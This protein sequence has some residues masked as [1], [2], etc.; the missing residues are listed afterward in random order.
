MKATFLQLISLDPHLTPLLQ[1]IRNFSPQFTT[2]ARCR[3]N[4]VKAFKSGGR[5]IMLTTCGRD[6][7]RYVWS[8][9][10]L[11][12]TLSPP[13]MPRHYVQLTARAIASDCIMLSHA[14]MLFLPVCD[15]M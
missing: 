13:T 6:V 11:C 4:Y 12:H 7:L 2:E 3:K 1:T 15:I 8:V 9:F 14:K 10:V 5:G